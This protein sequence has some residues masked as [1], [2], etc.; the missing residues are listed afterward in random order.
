MRM[1]FSADQVFFLKWGPCS[2]RRQARAKKV[3][4]FTKRFFKKKVYSLGEPP[5][6]IGIGNR[7]LEEGHH[8]P[9]IGRGKRRFFW[10]EV[11]YVFWEAFPLVGS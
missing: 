4:T 7:I 5:H 10:L 9:G 8:G 6:L 3:R 2:E 1:R 11:R